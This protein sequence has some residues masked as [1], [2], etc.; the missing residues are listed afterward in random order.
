MAAKK[1]KARGQK[2]ASKHAGH[3][4]HMCQLASKRLMQQAATL[5]YGAKYICFICGRSAAKASNL[6]EPT[7][8]RTPYY[9]E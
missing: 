6:C 3:E 8:M 9:A 4:K 5:A 1:T 7:Q 2:L